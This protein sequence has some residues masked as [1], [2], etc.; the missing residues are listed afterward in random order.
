MGIQIKPLMNSS[1]SSLRISKSSPGDVLI[2]T[3]TNISNVIYNNNNNKIRYT[4]Q[5]VL[6]ITCRQVVCTYVQRVWVCYNT[7][8]IS[9]WTWTRGSW[10]QEAKVRSTEASISRVIR[11]LRWGDLRNA[12]MSVWSLFWWCPLMLR[13]EFSPSSSVMDLGYAGTNMFPWFWSTTLLT[14]ASVDTMI[15]VP[16]M[17]VL[18]TFPYLNS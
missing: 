4:N 15:G 7:F 6:Y 12:L 11:S 16:I 1:N 18:N 9:S 14:S 3:L 10:A 17:F 5:N 2:N 13:I 8:L